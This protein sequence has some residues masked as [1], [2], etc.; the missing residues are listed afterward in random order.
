MTRHQLV[1]FTI[2]ITAIAIST[3]AI[4]AVAVIVLGD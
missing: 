3:I 2:G 4:A 1:W